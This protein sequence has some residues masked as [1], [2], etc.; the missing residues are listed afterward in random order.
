MGAM[1]ILLA[2]CFTGERVVRKGSVIIIDGLHYCTSLLLS[3]RFAGIIRTASASVC[4]F[5]D[6]RK[7]EG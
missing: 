7:H 1:L 4:G 6:G 5:H 2:K 3:H